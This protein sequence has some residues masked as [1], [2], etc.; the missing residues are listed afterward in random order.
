MQQKV[1]IILIWLK[2][3]APFVL[4][5]ILY[6]GNSYYQNMQTAKKKAD[7]KRY[8]LITALAWVGSMKHRDEPND[9]ICFRDSLLEEHNLTND[10]LK[11][12]IESYKNKA[13]D[14]GNM[15]AYIKSYVDSLLLIEDSLRHVADSLAVAD[16]LEA[17]DSIK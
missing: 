17:I 9:Y 3:I 6:F 2:R 15:T 1:G 5:A 7:E 12:F 10:S 16:S 8:A 13:E 14:L 11:M 4:I